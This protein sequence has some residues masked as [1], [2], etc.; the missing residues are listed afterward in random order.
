ML[1]FKPEHVPAILDRTKTQTR[2]MWKRARAKVC[3]VHQCTTKLYDR[4]GVFALVKIR[5]VRQE[6]LVAISHEDAVREGYANVPD[7]L[8]AFARIN[9][10]K[11]TLDDLVVWVVDFELVEDLT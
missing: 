6:K 4:T 5:A 11:G 9:R 1:L 10:T 8:A 3:S 7:Y 2:R